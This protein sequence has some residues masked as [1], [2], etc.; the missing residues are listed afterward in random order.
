MDKNSDRETLVLVLESAA[1]LLAQ[2]AV[3]VRYHEFGHPSITNNCVGT[4]NAAV[5]CLMLAE[6][7]SG[8][9]IDQ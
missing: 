2:E 8:R 5:R 7:L 3:Q 1:K 4:L 6:K 9:K